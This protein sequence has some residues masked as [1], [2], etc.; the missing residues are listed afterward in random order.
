MDGTT[1]K[2][3]TDTSLEPDSTARAAPMDEVALSLSERLSVSI[4][5]GATLGISEEWS[6]GSLLERPSNVGRT[7]DEDGSKESVGAG[8]FETP[9]FTT[10]CCSGCAGL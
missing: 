6:P 3:G 5:R 4:S 2:V 1:V 8:K 7:P 9:L 10:G